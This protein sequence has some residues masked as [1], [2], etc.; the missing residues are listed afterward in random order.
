[1]APELR[2]SIETAMDQIAKGLKDKEV[3][4]RETLDIF[5]KKFKFFK[6]NV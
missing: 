3:V 2:S 5:K 6:D 4:L 1:M